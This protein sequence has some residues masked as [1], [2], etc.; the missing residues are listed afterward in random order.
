M[1]KRTKRTLAISGKVLLRV[2][3]ASVLCAIMYLSMMFIAT[4][5]FSEVIGYQIHFHCHRS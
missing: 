2:V 1:K 3:L 4:A 5:M